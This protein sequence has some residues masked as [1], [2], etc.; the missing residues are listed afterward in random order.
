VH[1]AEHHDVDDHRRLLDLVVAGDEDAAA[2]LWRTHLTESAT[3]VLEHLGADTVVDIVG[4]H[5][6]GA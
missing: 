2:A 4:P 3:M 6:F 5:G 1:A